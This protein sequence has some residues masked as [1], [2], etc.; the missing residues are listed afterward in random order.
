MA[1]SV[2]VL[3]E[4]I[5]GLI[6]VQEWD[7]RTREGIQ[8]FRELRAK[9]LPSVALDGDLVYEAIIPGQE[10]ISVEIRRRHLEKN[11]V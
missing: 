2:R 6:D 4:E 11:A 8:R 7:M 3:P 1:E 10:E 9:S 5:Q